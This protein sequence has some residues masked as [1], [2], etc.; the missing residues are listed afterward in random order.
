MLQIP[1]CWV[2]RYEDSEY[3]YEIISNVQY[4]ENYKAYAHTRADGSIADYFYYS[5]FGGS[6]SATKIRSLSGQT[7]AQ[8]LTAQQEITGCQA[9]GTK[10]YTH[11]WSQREL[12]RTLCILMGKFFEYGASESISY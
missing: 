7:L 2:Y 9:N 11:T 1:L 3:E 4:D 5:M 6:G 10:W 8:S 12:I